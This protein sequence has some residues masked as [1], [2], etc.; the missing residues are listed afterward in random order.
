VRCTPCPA[1]C[2]L[3]IIHN[4]SRPAPEWCIASLRLSL[5]VP[6]LN[7]DGCPAPSL[8]GLPKTAKPADLLTGS[9]HNSKRGALKAGTGSAPKVG[10]RKRLTGRHAD[11]AP[12][13][14]EIQ[15]GVGRAGSGPGRVET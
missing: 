14:L 8:L 6:L 4:S 3:H 1:L 11:G 10:P 9:D 2:V 15:V 13:L 7:A 5:P 12:L